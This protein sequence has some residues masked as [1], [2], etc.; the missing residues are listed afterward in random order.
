MRRRLALLLPLLPRRAAAQ[1]ADP[2][3]GPGS[4]PIR[5]IVPFATGGGADITARIV[6]PP[7]ADALG[8]AILVENRPGGRGIPGAE[9][10]ARAAPD[11]LT[12]GLSN[13]APLGMA[14]L[15][16]RPAYDPDHDFTHV[17]LIA[18]TPSVLLVAAGS[19]LQDMATWLRAGR[20][21]TRGLTFG[22]PMTGS[23]QHLQGEMLAKA[24]G[25]R[26]FHVA[27]RGTAE[28]LPDLLN[29]Q[30]DS[31]IVPLAS[32]M[33]AVQGGQAR[34]LAQSG[35]EGMP[36]VPSFAALGYPQLTATVWL[37]LSGPRGLPPALVARLNA[38]VNRVIARPEVA[39]RLRAAGLAPPARPL[40]A[41]AYRQ[42]VADFQAAWRPAV[43]ASGMGAKE[44]P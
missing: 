34:A 8:R 43:Q 9:A 21:W 12:L 25:A 42:L 11:G 24:S 10:L 26:L 30:V 1:P 7:L 44:E 40:D 13:T 35:P 29:G 18:E 14:P 27:Y 32:V 3:P 39:A 16:D 31:L 19:R 4:A 2:L 23:L 5:L 33:P 41:A 38:E 17:A 36:G 6:A 15:V 28:A 20:S 37:G 22:S